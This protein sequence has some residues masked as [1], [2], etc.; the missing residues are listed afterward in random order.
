MKLKKCLKNLGLKEL[1]MI[2]DKWVC[3]ADDGQF[4]AWYY[5]RKIHEYFIIKGHFRKA[6]DNKN[7]KGFITS[8][9][10]EYLKLKVLDLK[11][12]KQKL[13][14]VLKSLG[15]IYNKGGVSA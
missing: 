11:D 10:K 15:I 14:S 7:H 9:L 8:E 4:E 2:N 6:Y 5:R 13:Q 12:D 1:Q 3:C